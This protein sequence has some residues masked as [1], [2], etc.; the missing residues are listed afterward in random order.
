MSYGN[1]RR[2]AKLE[3]KVGASKQTP[4]ELQAEIESMRAYLERIFSLKFSDEVADPALALVEI[5]EYEIW[6]EALIN[7]DEP[8]FKIPTTPE[9]HAAY[10]PLV[11]ERLKTRGKEMRLQF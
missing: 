9:D 3:E 7:P 2:I 6:Y 4:E 1:K 5:I 10:A 11:K 8:Q